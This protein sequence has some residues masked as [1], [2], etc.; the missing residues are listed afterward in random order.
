MPRPKAKPSPVPKPASSRPAPPPSRTN[1][2]PPKMFKIGQWTG[3]GEG[4]KVVLYGRSGVGK[5]TL[6]ALAPTPVFIGLD[7]GGRKIRHPETGQPL[8]RIEGIETFDDFL[9]ATRQKGLLKKGETLVVDTFT[10]LE[11]LAE[12]YIFRTIKHEKG[13]T[14]NHLEG[15][16]YGKGYVHL[17]D[18]MRLVLQNFDALVRQGINVVPICQN[19]TV[20]KANPSGTD[21]LY[22]GPKV[23]HP[24]SEK[25]S[26]RL[27]LCEWADHVVNVTYR[28]AAVEAA[29]GDKIGKATGTITRILYTHPQPHF[30]AKTRTLEE[31][32]VT[33]EDTGDDS[34][35]QF[36]FPED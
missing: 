10:L 9:S 22:D 35:W 18:T 2:S 36:I 30:F 23:S 8:R 31:A 29:R 32:A 27:M 13:W 28:E 19:M 7:D 1:T 12:P 33:F 6:A 20:R 17:H 26:V 34:L 24:S 21:Y 5:T 14:V 11:A 15:Y 4:E 16:G 25:N 3:S